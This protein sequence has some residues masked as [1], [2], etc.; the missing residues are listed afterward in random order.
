MRETPSQTAGPY[1]HIGM[2]DAAGPALIGSRMR[3]DGAR[4]EAVTLVGRVIDGDGA[5]VTDALIELWQPD[6]EGRFPPGSDPSLSNLG[7]A[8]CDD[9]GCYMFETVRPGAV[10]GAGAPHGAMMIYARGM[11]RALHLRCY[12]EGDP[13]NAGDPLL[14]AAGAR[15][16]TLIA[17]RDGAVWRLDIRLQGAN[18]TAFLDV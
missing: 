3:R 13:A 5:P 12:F 9:E 8:A 6:A 10:P 2:T 18:E 7:R 15:A 11:N 14:R 17:R 4:G 1:L 16:R